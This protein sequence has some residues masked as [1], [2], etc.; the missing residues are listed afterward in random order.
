MVLLAV[1]M[2]AT[3]RRSATRRL[4]LALPIGMLLH[5]VWDGAFTSTEVFWWPFSGGW[6][7][8]EVPSIARGWWNVLLELAGLLALAWVWRATGLSDA[9]RRRTFLRTGQLTDVR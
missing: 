5:I 4:L 8:H 2:I 7:D 3:K 6:G 9:A 1:V